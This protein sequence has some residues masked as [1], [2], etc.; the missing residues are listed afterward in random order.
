MMRVIHQLEQITITG[1]D[2][3]PQ[4]LLTT[5]Y[6]TEPSTSS[7][8]Y[9]SIS[10]AG[11]IEGIHDLADAF[12]LGTQ[13]IR[14][15]FPGA[16]VFGEQI[17]AESS[18]DIERHGQVFGMLLFQELEQNTGETEYSGGR[19]TFMR[20]ETRAGAAGKRKISAVSQRMTIDQIQD[21]R[22]K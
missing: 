2:L 6:A 13:L 17:I 18:T 7:A 20:A 21:R 4:P 19:F 12:H 5:E 14:H 15:L 22:H 1:D 11:D 8:S 3:D 16:F 10:N 9:P